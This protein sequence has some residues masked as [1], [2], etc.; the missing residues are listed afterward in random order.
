IQSP[1]DVLR[2]TLTSI[3]YPTMTLLSATMI[4]TVIRSAAAAHE[5]AL[6]ILRDEQKLAEARLSVLQSQL[7]PHFLFNS[8]N[9]L[10]A[11]LRRDPPAAKSMLQRLEAFYLAT[12][13][14]DDRASLTLGE[15]LG[16]VQQ[17]VEIERVRFGERLQLHMDV[18]AASA[19]LHVP[20]LI[21]Q[22]IVEN[23]V[24]HGIAR[25]PGPGFVSIRASSQEGRVLVSVSNNRD[26]TATPAKEGIG[27]RNTRERLTLAFHGEAEMRL[28][29]VGTQALVEISMPES[30][31]P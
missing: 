22:P 21:L 26:A 23:A 20:P 4:A 1:I 7:Q 16:Q 6:T 14:P 9:S 29:F 15:E 8:L 10:A 12:S 24:R 2:T 13:A 3:T 17:Y 11:L 31:T 5:R 19:R 18:D 28:A 30:E 25:V 27:L